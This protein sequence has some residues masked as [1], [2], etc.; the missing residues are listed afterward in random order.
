M[1]M[2]APQHHQA[3][4]R[5]GHGPCHRLRERRLHRR[6]RVQI[7]YDP[8]HRGH[9]HIEVRQVLGAEFVQKHGGGNRLQDVISHHDEE[10]IQRH[11]DGAPVF[12][13]AD[14]EQA[15]PHRPCFRSR[16]VA[17]QYTGNSKWPPTSVASRMLALACV[18]RQ[19]PNKIAHHLNSDADVKPPRELTP[20]FYGCYDWHSSVHGHWLLARLARHLPGRAVRRRGRGRRWSAASRRPISRA[21]WST[22]SGGTRELRA[23]VRPGLAAAACGRV[24]RMERSR[25]APVVGRADAAGARGGGAR[26]A[27]GC[28]SSR[29]PCASGEH[30]QT[31][32]AL[33]LML[34]WARIAGTREFEGLL[35][36]RISALLPERSRL[37]RS[38]TSLRARTSSRPAWRKPT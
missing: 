38:P 35:R 13:L 15:S 29:V 2:I 19:Y 34:D 21:R 23:P 4:H 12:S 37:R 32:F 18:H 1:P 6:L 9:Q 33:G 27:P 31:A 24:A 17:N 8:A 11:E 20:A 30:S 28:R 25:G 5:H 26:R 3:Q 14:V 7:R 22:R 36:S 10:Q 16:H